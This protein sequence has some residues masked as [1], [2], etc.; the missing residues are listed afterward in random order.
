MLWKW[1]SAPQWNAEQCIGFALQK[2]GIIIIFV[3]TLIELISFQIAYNFIQNN[4]MILCCCIDGVV[5]LVDILS[6]F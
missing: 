5:G 1:K 3:F 6:F 4:H 2:E